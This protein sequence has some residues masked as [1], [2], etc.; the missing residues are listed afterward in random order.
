MDMD[1]AVELERFKGNNAEPMEGEELIPESAEDNMVEPELDTGMINTLVANGVPELAAKHAVF[2]AGG[3]ADE[4][5]M[6]FYSHIED[7][8]I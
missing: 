4:A 2:N 5:I 7:P 1:A 8:V 6:W 3:S